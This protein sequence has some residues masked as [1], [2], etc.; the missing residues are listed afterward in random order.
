MREK[1]EEEGKTRGRV[2][3]R[4][5]GR[6]KCEEWKDERREKRGKVPCFSQYRSRPS[7]QYLLE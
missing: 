1:E 4:K 3:V 7:T 6:V 2:S 5:E